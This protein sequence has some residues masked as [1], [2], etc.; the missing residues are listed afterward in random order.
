MAQRIFQFPIKWF[1]ALAIILQLAACGG[2]SESSGGASGAT[3]SGESVISGSVGDGPVAGATLR[4]YDRNGTLVQTETSDSAANYTARIRAAADAYPLTIRVIGG[5]DMVTGRAPDF[6]MTSMV[7]DESSDVVNINPFTTLIVESARGM[8]GGLTPANVAAAKTAVMSQL[9][10]GLDPSFVADPI[11]TPINN[12]NVAVI[13]K[14]SE[15]LGEMIRRARDTLMVSATVTNADEVVAALADDLVDGVIDGV[16]G[17]NAEPRIAAVSTLAAGQVL[18]EAMSN[19]L[20]VDGVNATA[21]LDNAIVTTH[22]TVPANRLSNG[23]VLNT[24]MLEQARV[25]IDAA[26]ALAPSAALSAIATTLDTLSTGSLPSAVVAVLPADTSDDLD[27][28]IAAA[29]TTSDNDLDA[30]ND[31]VAGN[32]GSTPPAGNSAPV[33]SGTP[34]SSVAED[35]AYSFTPSATDSDGDTLSFSISNRPSWASF[36]SNT[37]R[38]SGTP[39]NSNVG[40]YGNITIRVSDGS[41]SDSIG[42]FSI[43]VNNTNDAPVISGSPATAVNQGVAYSFQPTASDVDGDNLT[44]SIS[45]RPSWASFNTSTGR[46]TGTPAAGNV[47]T[48]SGIAISVSD[49]SR[50][51]SLPA[52]S[53]T[54]NSTA[55]QTGSAS[56]SWNAPVTRANGS[57]LAMNEIESY[58]LYYG[59]AAGSYNNSVPVNDPYTNSLTISDLPVGTYYFVITATDMDGLESGYSNMATKVV[60]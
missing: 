39:R 15:A 45:S 51:V 29:P 11:G 5:I 46:L 28:V 17:S 40:T 58:R 52:F 50:T 37:G 8:S 1:I 55:P 35:S 7:S 41:A 53:I 36:N 16:G 4:I 42:P 47:G 43:R 54:V 22:P 49:G 12:N 18:V 6:T 60:Q 14:A 20:R 48:H 38:L 56:L 26:N 30:V 3:V 21:A 31:V 32:G 13:V 10:F 27:A 2:G 44:F 24:E 59:T 33:L 25:A 19:N 23:V 57:A 9:N 34:A